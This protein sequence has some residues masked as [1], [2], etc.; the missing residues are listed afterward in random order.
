MC[1]GICRRKKKQIN[2]FFFSSFFFFFFLFGFI[3]GS[4]VIVAA[5]KK[6]R[7]K[8]AF[9]NLNR[10]QMASNYFSLLFFF[11]VCVCRLLMYNVLDVWGSLLQKGKQGVQTTFMC[12][13]DVCGRACLCAF[14]KK[15]PNC[16]FLFFFFFFFA[17]FMWVRS[18]LPS[19][20]EKKGSIACMLRAA[21]AKRRKKSLN[22]SKKKKN[23]WVSAVQGVIQKKELYCFAIIFFKYVVV[24]LS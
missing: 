20:V 19:C 2:C 22:S 1:A 3:V 5:L 6:E 17:R 16:L 10:T 13:W 4:F 23:D 14:K 11:C 9:D 7:Q 18:P 15:K 8:E 21:Q 12:A 24:A